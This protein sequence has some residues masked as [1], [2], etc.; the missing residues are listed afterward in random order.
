MPNLPDPLDPEFV[1]VLWILDH[2]EWIPATIFT[3]AVIALFY[4]VLYGGWRDGP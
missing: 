1:P 4:F 2:P 3:V